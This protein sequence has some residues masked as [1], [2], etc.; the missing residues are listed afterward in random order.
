MAVRDW[1]VT[2]TGREDAPGGSFVVAQYRRFR[3]E[4]PM[5]CFKARRKEAE[6]Q[7]SEYRGMVNAWLMIKA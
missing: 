7:F 6:L 2:E 4:L 3:R 5:M 1:L